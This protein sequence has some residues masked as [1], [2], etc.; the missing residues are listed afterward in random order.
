MVPTGSGL[1]DASIVRAIGV[2]DDCVGLWAGLVVIGLKVGD[3]CTYAW[4][5][6]RPS[7]R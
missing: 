5:A 6:G 1:L 7:L 4:M 2:E 3:I